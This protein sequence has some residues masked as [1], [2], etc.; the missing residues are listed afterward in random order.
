M[1]NWLFPQEVNFFE[2]FEKHAEIL[3][4]ASHE[5]L[6][7]VVQDQFHL[8]QKEDRIKVLEHQ[9]D[10]IVHHC[11]EALRKTFITPI[12][13]EDI[14][15]LISTMDDIMDA[16]NTAYTC[17]VV[18][19]VE[20]S[21]SEL[22]KMAQIIHDSCLKV[23]QAVKGLRNLKNAELINEACVSIHHLENEAD[24]LLHSSVGN[25]FAEGDDSLLIIKW[26]EIYE[27]LEDATDRCEDVADVVQGILLENL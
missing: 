24:E 26:K 16:I 19:R 21:T 20:S 22:K 1:L 27:I 14:Y 13:R 10:D 11:I 4:K 25:L 12:N 18:Y 15:R 3:V 2:F 23:Q 9:A 8:V 17:L 7:V 5:F 6:D